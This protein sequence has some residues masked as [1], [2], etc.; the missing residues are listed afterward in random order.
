MY[1]FAKRTWACSAVG[2]AAYIG[3]G[4]VPTVVDT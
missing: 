3:H 4:I 2:L 1:M